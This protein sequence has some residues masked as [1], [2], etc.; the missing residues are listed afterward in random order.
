MLWLLTTLASTRAP[1][2]VYVKDRLA[3]AEEPITVTT[4]QDVVE[5]WLA[6]AEL[7]PVIQAQR[8]VAVLE[9]VPTPLPTTGTAPML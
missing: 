8:G 6:L 4:W 3:K 2:V 7:L 1:T 9:C 5:S